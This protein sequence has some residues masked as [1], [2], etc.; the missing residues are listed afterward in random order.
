[1]KIKTG[2]PDEKNTNMEWN[3]TLKSLSRNKENCWRT[4]KTKG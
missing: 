2:N 1:M 4:K 3:L